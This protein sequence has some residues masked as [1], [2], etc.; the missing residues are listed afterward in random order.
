MLKVSMSIHTI[1]LHPSYS[2]HELFR[3]SVTPYVETNRLRPRVRAIQ[4]TRPMAYRAKLLGRALLA[5]RTDPN[6]FWM[7]L[8]RNPEVAFLST[9]ATTTPAASL[10]KPAVTA[11]VTVGRV[12][13]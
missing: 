2:R 12:Q 7:L 3:R 11:A 10:P 4:K 6:C 5:D 8:S 1:G 9:T 13:L